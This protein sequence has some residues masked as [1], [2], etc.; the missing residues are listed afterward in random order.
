MSS[1]FRES[2]GRGRSG[3]RFWHVESSRH[4][5]YGHSRDH[6]HSRDRV[7]EQKHI[8][9]VDTLVVVSPP[10]RPNRVAAENQAQTAVVELGGSPRITQLFQLSF[11][12]DG[13]GG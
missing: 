2:Y 8:L 6:G 11:D 10:P 12:L 9:V 3:R 5:R 13:R 4:L 7:F 1:V